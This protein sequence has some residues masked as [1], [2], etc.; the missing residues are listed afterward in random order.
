MT[1][2]DCVVDDRL[3][4]LVGVSRA[5]GMVSHSE[6]SPIPALA[7]DLGRC[8]ERLLS[9]R[10]LPGPQRG[11]WVPMSARF[12]GRAGCPSLLFRAVLSASPILS[13]SKGQNRGASLPQSN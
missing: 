5:F 12:G 2:L 10:I 11:L 6:P 13:H 4:E 7:G 3:G 1:L 8:P 9:Q